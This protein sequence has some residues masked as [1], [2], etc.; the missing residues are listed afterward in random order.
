[1]AEFV[2]IGVPDESY[3]DWFLEASAKRGRSEVRVATPWGPK[4]ATVEEYRLLDETGPD[5]VEVRFGGKLGPF[6]VLGVAHIPQQT[7]I[8][9]VD[10]AEEDE[11]ELLPLLSDDRALTP[12][13]WFFGYEGQ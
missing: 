6:A 8:L 13:E 7:G 3:I 2:I 1:M 5:Q 10:I 9:S 12:D 11:P 4:L